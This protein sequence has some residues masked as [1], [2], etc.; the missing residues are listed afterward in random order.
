[1]H[2]NPTPIDPIDYLV[3]GHLT[4]DLTPE[5]SI[6]GGTA[7]YAT[8]TAKAMGVRVGVITAGE[9]DHMTPEMEGV[10][11]VN[12]PSEQTTTFENIPGKD[13][14]IQYVHELAPG[15]NASHVPTTWL[16]TPIIHLG[17]VAQ[18]VDPKLPRSFPDSFIGLTPQGWLR[19]WDDS[20]KVHVAEW[21]EAGFVL[22]KATAAVLSIEDVDGDETRIEE[23]MSRIRILVITEGPEGARLYWN[24][25]MRRFRPPRVEVAE[26]TG[27]GDIFAA[28]FFI[29]L[30]QT[31]DP[32][33]AAHFATLVAS[34]LVTRSGV[35]SI[36]TPE[37]TRN[38]L[39]GTIKEY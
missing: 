33:E 37:E 24:G 7:L 38:Y 4:R 8:L 14:R 5:G 25:N 26:D 30:H 3:I 29:R 34:N 10:T 22:E 16:D 12:L 27:A 36:P 13:R 23:M 11:L 31:Q 18:E 17:P 28:A 2:N 9:Y 6:V 35:D 39:M 19:G 32:L 21:P 1:M 20:G 15:L